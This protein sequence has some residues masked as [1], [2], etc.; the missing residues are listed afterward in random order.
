MT[1]IYFQKAVF[2]KMLSYVKVI[3]MKKALNDKL[4]LSLSYRCD[5]VRFVLTGAHF[6]CTEQTYNAIYQR[7]IC[8]RAKPIYF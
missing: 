4:E 7:E 3:A 6:E 2:R 8:I 5:L 1:Y